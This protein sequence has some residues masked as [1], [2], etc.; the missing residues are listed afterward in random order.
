MCL[1]ETQ[2]WLKGRGRI[3]GGGSG[4]LSILYSYNNT[5]NSKEFT[6]PYCRDRLM[7]VERQVFGVACR[8][9]RIEHRLIRPHTLRTNRLVERFNDG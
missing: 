4:I 6:D 5:D 2:T 8:S 7:K 3:F 9:R 1:S